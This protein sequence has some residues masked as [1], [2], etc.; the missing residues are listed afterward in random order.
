MAV[1]AMNAVVSHANSNVD[2]IWITWRPAN[3][4]TCKLHRY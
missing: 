4:R 2:S 3:R 1:Y